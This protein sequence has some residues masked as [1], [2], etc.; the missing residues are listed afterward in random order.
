VK[1]GAQVEQG[2]ALERHGRVR[3]SYVPHGLVLLVTLVRAEGSG[4]DKA[5]VP[6]GRVCT[7]KQYA[8]LGQ[9]RAARRA[10]IWR[11][12]R[13]KAYRGLFALELQRSAFPGTYPR[14]VGG[15]E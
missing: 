15:A 9:G 2:K 8:F 12:K 6:L 3:T 13:G 4:C 1:N 10:V 5:A 11:E 14:L 7:A